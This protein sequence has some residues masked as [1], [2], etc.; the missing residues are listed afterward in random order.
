MATLDVM[1]TNNAT[2][3]LFA[4][5]DA[6]VLELDVKGGEGLLFPDTSGVGNDGYFY[7][8]LQGEDGAWEVVKVTERATDKFTIE[9]NVDSSTGAAQAFAGDDIVS[10]RPVASIFTDIMA[11]IN[12][13]NGAD[14]IIPA[15]AGTA[16]IFHQATAPPGWTTDEAV[17]DCVLAFKGGSDAYDDT[18]GTLVGSWTQPN[19]DHTIVHT[20]ELDHIHAVNVD[21]HNHQI[22]D[23]ATQKN[24][25]VDGNPINLTKGHNT[26]SNKVLIVHVTGGDGYAPNEDVWT[27]N[28]VDPV[29]S[30]QPDDATT[31]SQSTDDS[32]V[33][34]P[35]NTYRPYAALS[36]CAVRDA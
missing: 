36:I 34:A 19:H 31:D 17:A 21:N 15:P 35:V 24:F 30:E 13:T 2:G 20:H 16:M 14:V 18:A 25:N 9:R 1:V 6:I 3:S 7:V 12:D 23:D 10:L 33:G 5:I 11:W 22:Y 26:A 8:T 4:G 27:A 32:G 28:A 29:D